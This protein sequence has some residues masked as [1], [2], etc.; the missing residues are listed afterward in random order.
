MSS[1]I[2]PWAKKL[3]L[4]AAEDEASIQIAEIPDMDH[5]DFM[6]NKRWRSL[7]KRF[8]RN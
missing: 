7:S 2:D 4:K 3:L 8:S 5:S 6:L 1:A